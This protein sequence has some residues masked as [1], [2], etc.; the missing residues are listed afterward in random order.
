M[1]EDGSLCFIPIERV[2]SPRKICSGT[3]E[4]RAQEAQH[5][6]DQEDPDVFDVVDLNRL[7][8]YAE[9]DGLAIKARSPVVA[10][11]ALAHSPPGDFARGGAGLAP[12]RSSRPPNQ[13]HS[14]STSLAMR[15][16]MERKT[17]SVSQARPSGAG[18]RPAAVPDEPAVTAAA[19]LLE[20]NAGMKGKKLQVPPGTM[21]R[22]RQATSARHDPL[23]D[24]LVRICM[25]VA[26]RAKLF[27]VA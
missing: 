8:E 16:H 19:V 24:E 3:A 18:P 13:M 25:S 6:A 26:Q 22:R 11:S 21:L 2:A 14:S 10:Q 1:V 23:G 15:P 7:L 17:D 5:N 4:G 9:D 12:S 27:F 20:S